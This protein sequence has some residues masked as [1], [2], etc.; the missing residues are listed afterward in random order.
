VY[1]AEASALAAR[2]ARVLLRAEAARA[3]VHLWALRQRELDAVP[4]V[5]PGVPDPAP[6]AGATAGECGHG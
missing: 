4:G 3:T 1:A 5:V 6:A 2:E